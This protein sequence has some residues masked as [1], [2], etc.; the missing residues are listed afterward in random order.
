MAKTINITL[1]SIFIL[2]DFYI[3]KV[4]LYFCAYNLSIIYKVL[5]SKVSF[6]NSCLVL[7]YL[8]A[9]ETKIEP[10][11]FYEKMINH[12]KPLIVRSSKRTEISGTICYIKLRNL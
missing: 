8:D 5:T 11:Q 2:I 3:K 7:H 9:S 6:L 4:Y 12:S 10:T 1:K